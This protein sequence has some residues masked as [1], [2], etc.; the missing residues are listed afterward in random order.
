MTDI[1]ESLLTSIYTRLTQ[2]TTLKSLM[3]GSVRL[4]LTWA[5]PEATFPYLVHRLDMSRI[6]DWSPKVRFTY[7]LDIW[8]YSS[9]ADEIFDIREQLMN[10]LDN[11]QGTTSDGV[12][13]WMWKQTSGLIPETAENIWHLAIQMNLRCIESKEI[14]VLLKR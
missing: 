8:S 10:L 3:G 9:N 6:A 11:Y 1:N 12:D 4:S 14:G 2:D 5:P 13:F 7:L